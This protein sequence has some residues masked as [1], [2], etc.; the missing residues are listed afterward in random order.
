[1]PEGCER[2][3][4][5]PSSFSHPMPTLERQFSLNSIHSW[6][7]DSNPLLQGPTINIHALAKPLMKR[8]YHRQALAFIAKDTPGQPLSREMIDIYTSYLSCKYVLLETQLRVLEHLEDF[9]IYTCALEWAAKLVPRM[10]LDGRLK[11]RACSVVKALLAHK[12]GLS[13]PGTVKDILVARRDLGEPGL[14]ESILG[15]ISYNT[16]RT[17]VLA[18]LLDSKAGYVSLWACTLIERLAIDPSFVA[19][20]IQDSDALMKMLFNT[21]RRVR[22]VKLHQAARGSALV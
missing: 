1:M 20:A 12:I 11:H 19:V 21:A 6:W 10:L 9:G 17:A 14:A 8:M 2:G 18:A 3:C 4:A 13:T 5:S 7:S 16:E 22:V 15:A